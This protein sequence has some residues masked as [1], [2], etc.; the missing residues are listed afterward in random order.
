M[1]TTPFLNKKAFAISALRRS[2]YK[3]PPSWVCDKKSHI[4]Y[5]QWRC[6]ICNGVYKKKETQKD[7]I[8]PIV[9]PQKGWEGF[10]VYIERL[11]AEESG[12]Q[13]I[14]KNCHKLKSG[15]ENVVRRKSRARKAKIKQD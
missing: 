12:W 7:H 6:N 1:T 4:G 3:W 2:T 11:Y 8:H 9:Q 15:K 10:D 13:R 14:C 5:N